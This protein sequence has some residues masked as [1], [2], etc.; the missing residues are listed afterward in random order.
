MTSARASYPGTGSAICNRFLLPHMPKIEGSVLAGSWKVKANSTLQ[1]SWNWAGLMDGCKQR[2]KNAVS[3]RPDCTKV[4]CRSNRGYTMETVRMCIVEYTRHHNLI[5]FLYYSL[6]CT[7]YLCVFNVA[8]PP[9]KNN[10]WK[11]LCIYN[12]FL[13]R[14]QW[15]IVSS[16]QEKVEFRKKKK[17]FSCF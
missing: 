14:R 5:L 17:V 7:T 10:K 9:Y 3:W 12:S 11:T 15:I 1:P 13:L 4:L 6:I 2:A 16:S 8:M